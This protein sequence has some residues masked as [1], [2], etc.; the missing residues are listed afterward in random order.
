[1][2][3]RRTVD[4]E[5]FE[6]YL[7]GRYFWNQ[8]TEEGLKKGLEY[9]DRAAAKD[10]NYGPAYAGLADSY[11][12][13]AN[14]GY[15]PPKAVV[16]KAKAASL[17]ALELDDTLAE[18]HAT[19]GHI[20][21]EYDWN[22]T[23]AE[24]DYQ[25]AIELNPGYATGYHYYAVFLMDQGRLEQSIA[26]IRRAQEVDPLSRIILATAAYIYFYA[27]Q[28]DRQLEEIQKLQELD[29]NYYGLYFQRGRYY[30]GKGQYEKAIVELKKAVEFSHG[31]AHPL[32]SLGYVYALAGR[33]TEALGVLA[34]LEDRSR[35]SYI[36]E[37]YLAVVHAGLGEKE[38][39]LALLQKAYEERSL[40]HHVFLK[41]D[42][43]MDS[44]RSDPRFQELLR[45]I[46]LP[47]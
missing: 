7:K 34:E 5:A 11:L 23:A 15:I 13:L 19:R 29:P 17:R 33:R 6:L 47:P 27:H 35:K 46:G 24:R 12:L 37:V 3:S 26:Q 16:P 38:Q 32:S 2:P 36:P 20:L 31:Y 9:F 30:E 10:P 21:S 45:G 40:F 22:N 8:R 28:Y 1:L 43:Q 18:A 39:A 14:Y 25:R 42:P 44:L 4:P 41:V